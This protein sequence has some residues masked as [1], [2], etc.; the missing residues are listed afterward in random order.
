[1]P[2]VD[3]ERTFSRNHIYTV[4]EIKFRS[5]EI[6]EPTEYSGVVYLI[7]RAN[8]GREYWFTEQEGGGWVVDHT[9]ASFQLVHED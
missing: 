1:M 3:V 2:D 4:G 8:D 6:D 9:W 7:A 5:I